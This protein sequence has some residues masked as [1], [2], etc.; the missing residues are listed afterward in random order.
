M[1][2]RVISFILALAMVCSLLPGTAI[3]A[4]AAEADSY[5]YHSYTSGLPDNW[6]PPHLDFQ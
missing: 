5:T 6:N 2:N 1:K 3:G 4:A